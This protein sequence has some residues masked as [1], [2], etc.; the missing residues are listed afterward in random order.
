MVAKLLAGGLSAGVF[1]LWWP[2]NFPDEGLEW[3]VAR[4]VL[5][6][7]G[8]ELLVL[9]FAP[10]ERMALARVR[11]PRLPRRRRFVLPAALIALVVPLVLL[12]GARPLPEPAAKPRV[13]R[14]VTQ[15][16]IVRKPVVRRE[17]VVREV[18]VPVRVPVVVPE[19]VQPVQT[20]KPRRAAAETAKKPAPVASPAPSDSAASPTLA[21]GGDGDSTSSE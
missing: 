10:V 15:K 21:G 14:H 17:V 11:L 7:A 1:L 12:S 2:A 18:E 19:R 8:F 6:T 20:A 5:W 13:V 9:A 16:V 4:G 3:L